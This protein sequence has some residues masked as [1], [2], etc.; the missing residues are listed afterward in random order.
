MTTEPRRSLFTHAATA[1]MTRALA[2]VACLAMKAPLAQQLP[3]IRS[4][5]AVAHVSPAGLLGSV[6]AVRPLPNGRLIV[7]D[8]TWRQLL[9]LDSN[10]TKVRVLADSTAAT[11]R[12]YGGQF[13]A[14]IA[15]RGDSSLFIEPQSMSMTVLDTA[16]EIARVMGIPRPSDGIFLM[17]GPL[18]TPGFDGSGQLIYR[19]IGPISIPPFP[20]D[21]STPN[22]LPIIADS[23]PVYRVNVSTRQR[24]T[25]AW[26]RVPTYLASRTRDA[27]GV[28]RAL[29][30]VANPIPVVDVWAVMPDGRIA[31]VRGSDFHIDWINAEGMLVSTPRL[32]Y[33][34]ERLNDE[35]KQRI[36]DSAKVAADARGAAM[37]RAFQMNPTEP[38]PLIDA[39]MRPLGSVIARNS[40][41]PGARSIAEYVPSQF[42]SPPITQ[43]PDYRPAFEAGAAL[44]SPDGTLWIRTTAAS[45][46]G[47]IYYVIDNNGGLIDRV[48]V[49]YGRLITGFGKDVAYMGVLDSAGARLEKARLR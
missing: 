19:G 9:L 40:S 2:I 39:L 14:L 13:A 18:G 17:G 22:Y 49:P 16:G 25:V 1:A 42:V 47:A 31:I 43:L 12:V 3:P 11:G 27:T 6:S 21:A 8:L 46:Q 20:T 30:V 45:T 34:W 23:A 26:V 33:L 37:Q 28:P 7:H 29:R 41:G 32:P 10:L 15:Y 36:A 35:D 4:I 5:G 24:D 44:A 48:R 38:P